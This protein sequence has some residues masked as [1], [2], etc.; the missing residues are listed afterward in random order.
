MG[1]TCRFSLWLTACVCLLSL[2][3]HS[4]S[5]S[6]GDVS[7]KSDCHNNNL[8]AALRCQ[9]DTYGPNRAQTWLLSLAEESPYAA[10]ENIINAMGYQLLYK[11]KNVKL[12]IDLFAFNT[13]LFPQSANAFDSLAEAYWNDGQYEQ[14]VSAYRKAIDLG[15]QFGIH[16]LGFLPPT[17]YQR[18]ELPKEDSG[19]YLSVGNESADTVLIYL[20]GGP[21]TQLSVRHPYLNV[22]INGDNAIRVVY[23]HQ[24]TTLNPKLLTTHPVL[25][26]KQSQ[27]ENTLNVDILEKVLNRMASIHKRVVLAGH[28]YGASIVLEYL[29]TRS[30]L[31]DTVIV[32]GLDLNED[33]ESWDKLNPGQYIRWEQGTIAVIKEV[34][35]WVPDS[36]SIKA[37]FNTVADNLTQLVR[38]NMQNNYLRQIP[39]SVFPRMTAIFASFDEAN[40]RK[41]DQE[42]D[43]LHQKGARVIQV[44][45]DHHSMLTESLLKQ[46][47]APETIDS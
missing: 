30:N 16:H 40:G 3:F 22:L 37:R 41:S 21:D 6:A 4:D 7:S 28:S 33:I 13:R 12:A 2:N 35:G 9:I 31:A 15:Q 5:A 23:P 10:D 43:V 29:R 24:V 44:E 39:E 27:N 25:S 36:L 1:S 46:V 18:T 17:S 8:S 34:F 26:A 19:L 47:I 14:A 45:G 20:Q 42:I 32:M 38:T 11:E